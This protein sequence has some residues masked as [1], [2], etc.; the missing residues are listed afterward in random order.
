MAL[1]LLKHQK[2]YL[3]NK[4]PESDSAP[5]TQAL[6]LRKSNGDQNVPQ[7]QASADQN[8]PQDQNVT[9]E[10]AKRFVEPFV[11]TNTPWPILSDYT[12]S[13]VEE[14]WKLAIEDQ[15]YQQALA[16][17]PVDTPSVC[18]LP[19]GP[20]LKMDPQT[21]EAVCLRFWLMLLYQVSDIDYTPT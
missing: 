16:G 10:V 21:W 19:S 3:L 20:S 13:M 6:P 7:P 5:S 2:S 9:F 17:A 18:Q 12:Y 4:L 8:V 11:L 14:A 1:L 15:D